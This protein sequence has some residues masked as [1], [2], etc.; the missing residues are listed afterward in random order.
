M[1]CLDSKKLKEK[2]AEKTKAKREAD[3]RKKVQEDQARAIEEARFNQEFVEKAKEIYLSDY[4]DDGR[5]VY[6]LVRDLIRPP[7]APDGPPADPEPVPPATPESA[8]PAAAE[9]GVPA[10]PEY[11][12]VYNPPAGYD[13]QQMY[14]E[15]GEEMLLDESEI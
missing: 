13:P 10:T 6:E 8:T 1:D 4:E 7:V 14:G 5:T 11:G 9:P 3:R 2:L 15:T 12:P